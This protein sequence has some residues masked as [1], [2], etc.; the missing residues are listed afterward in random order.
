LR[1]P[2]ARHRR[3]ARCRRRRVT[4]AASQPSNSTACTREERPEELGSAGTATKVEAGPDLRGDA[5]ARA[6]RAAGELLRRERNYRGKSLPSWTTR[7]GGPRRGTERG[8]SGPDGWTR[9]M[10]CREGGTP[11]GGRCPTI[12]WDSS[13]GIRARPRIA[14][15]CE[16]AGT[17]DAILSP[18]GGG[19]GVSQQASED[20]LEHA[21]RKK[22]MRAD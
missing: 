17:L 5:A 1:G 19:G 18:S 3:E 15:C 10:S 21:S 7:A 14:E 20:S 2:G 11:L 6:A 8:F 16:S 22:T 13:Q 4:R 9:S 12:V